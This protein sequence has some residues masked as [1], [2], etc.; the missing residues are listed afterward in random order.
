MKEH[1]ITDKI[2]SKKTTKKISEKIELLGEQTKLDTK[3]FLN[4]RMLG[5]IFIFLI[6]ILFSKHGYIYAPILSIAYYFGITYVL[7]DYP[8]KERGLKLEHEAIFFF[9]ILELTLESGKNLS[10]ALDIT[11]SNT[12]GDLSNEFKKTLHE[13]KLG[14]SLIESL[15]DMK[16]RIPSETIN[17]TILN[18]TESSI[19]GSNIIASL[20]NQLEYLRNK[21][22]MEV[23]AKI[24]KLPTKISVLSVVFFI[25][26]ILLIVLSPVVIEFLLG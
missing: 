10:Q 16:K 24:N 20:N 6:F 1:L 18:I 2:Y 15:K 12:D 3:T 7:L 25:P 5:T 26:L 4:V 8:I 19:F 14:K 9:E 13:V 17:N 11:S 21:R 23:K 22:L